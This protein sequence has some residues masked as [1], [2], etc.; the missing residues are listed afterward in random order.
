ME[1]PIYPPIESRD[2]SDL[3]VFLM[4]RTQH[5]LPHC[6][7]SYFQYIMG[8]LGQRSCCNVFNVCL[9]QA[10]LNDIQEAS[11]LQCPQAPSGKLDSLQKACEKKLSTSVQN[12]NH[13]KCW[14]FI[15]VWKNLNSSLPLWESLSLLIQWFNGRQLTWSLPIKQVGM[16]RSL[17]G[18][19][20][21]LKSP[22]GQKAFLE[23]GISIPSKNIFKPKKGFRCF[24]P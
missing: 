6:L 12:L 23:F 4:M 1:I 21:Y 9:V 17:P 19:T 15:T 5:C 7:T 13:G 14:Y 18:R 8:L 16:T 3:Y 20:I 22:Y 24:L 11:S 10:C 2:L